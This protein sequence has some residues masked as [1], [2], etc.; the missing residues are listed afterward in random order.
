MPQPMGITS[1]IVNSAVEV[2]NF[3][4][5]PAL[6]SLVERD[7]FGGHPSENPNMH[8][9]NFLVKCDNVKLNGVSTDAI[10][11]RLF[12]FSLRDRGRDWLQNE[13]PNTLATWNALS[14]AFLS[15][16][17]PPGKTAKLR[18]NITLFAQLHSE[19][20]Y[21]AWERFKDL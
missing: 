18:A 14:R 8:L 3:E 15:K 1:S 10:R 7:Q 17:F 21:D 11:L 20:L 16:Y 4:L 9:C 6:I 2:N 5:R 19:S 13:E 12:P